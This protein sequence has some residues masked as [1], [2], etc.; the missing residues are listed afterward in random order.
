MKF[1]R[2]L[3]L[4]SLLFLSACKGGELPVEAPPKPAAA[5]VTMEIINPETAGQIQVTVKLNGPVPERKPEPVNAEA[6]CGAHWGGNPPL[7]QAVLVADGLV[8]NSFVYIRQGLKNYQYPAPEGTVKLDQ[9][10]CLYTPRVIGAR[11]NQPVEIANGDDLLHNV[12]SVTHANIPFN[13]AQP[14][15]GK[16]DT[17]LFG[18]PEVMVKTKCDIHPWMAAY[19]GVLDH[20][21]FGV[22]DD[23]GTLTLKGVP[24]GDYVIEAWHEVFGTVTQNVTL[25]AKEQKAVEFAFTSAAK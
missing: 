24:P 22:S 4:S 14:F 13:V 11:V 9:V 23:K 7:S 25:G 19:I 8:Q 21:F 5:P 12:H 15:K 16:S 1:A 18:K 3:G 20:P 10:G 6:S 2:Y 17:K